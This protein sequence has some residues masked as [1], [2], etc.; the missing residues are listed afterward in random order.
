MSWLDKVAI[1]TDVYI[2]Q[3]A[4]VCS[5]CGDAIASEL[6]REGTEDNDDW[7]AGHESDPFPQG[8]Y[9]NGGGEAD[10]AQFCDRVRHCVNAV[11]IVSSHKIGCP[12]GNPLTRDGA[13]ALCESIRRQILAPTKQGRLLGRLLCKVWHDYT[14]TPLLRVLPD[15]VA[16]K[17]LHDALVYL[18]RDEKCEVQPVMFTDLEHIYG[19][20]TNPNKTLAWRI[21]ATDE[22]GLTD[23]GAVKMPNYTT[24]RTV[25][26]LVAEAIAADDWY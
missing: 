15:Q 22:G 18:W 7:T 6:R 21:T 23:L 17:V 8:P 19:V 26:E 9:G 14:E 1:C 16:S 5:D 10:S 3:A 13:E 12:L 4:L 20:A 11:E 24:S 25:E 2:Y